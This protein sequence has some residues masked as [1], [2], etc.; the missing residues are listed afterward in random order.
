MAETASQYNINDI[1]EELRPYRNA[2]LNSA[3]GL[4]YTP[5]YLRTQF[6]NAQFPMA[7]PNVT[8]NPP[9]QAQ[10]SLPAPAPQPLFGVDYPVT[11]GRAFDPGR[12]GRGGLSGLAEAADSVDAD[13]QSRERGAPRYGYASGGILSKAADAVDADVTLGPGGT[14]LGGVY[15]V[16]GMPAPNLPVRIGTRT[17]GTIQVPGN[18]PMQP[19]Q[20]PG[21]I[22]GL[23]PPQ[24]TR[25]AMGGPGL[26]GWNTMN[27]SREGV[28]P[29]FVT[30]RPNSF[31]GSSQAAASGYNPAQYADD[32]V[33]GELART[34]GGNLIYT[35]PVG[36]G[37]PPSQATLDFGGNA[38]NNAGLVQQQID[39]ANNAPSQ[40]ERDQRLNALRNEIRS[41][42]GVPGFKK[43]GL[44]RLAEGGFP[45]DGPTNTIGMNTTATA[46][47]AANPFGG[48]TASINP[49]QAYGG[50]RVLGSGSNF[51]QQG[52][53]GVFQVSDPTRDAIQSVQALPTYFDNGEI[54]ANRTEGGAATTPLGIAN[55]IFDASGGLALG[56][57]QNAEYMSGLRPLSS[58]FGNTMNYIRGNPNAFQAGDISVGALTAPQMDAPPAVDVTAGLIDPNNVTQGVGSERMGPVGNIYTDRFVDN[59]NSG[60]YMDPYQ[61]AVTEVRRADALKAFNE[62]KQAR[63][64]QLIR[65]GAF[66]GNRRAVS[67]SLAERDLANQMDRITAEG[68]EGAYLNAQ[69]QYERDRAAKMGVDTTNQR[70]DLEVGGRNLDASLQGASLRTNAGL[71]A[72]LANQRSGLEAALANQNAGIN[73]GSRN[74]DASLT[75]QNLARTSGLAAAQSNQATRLTQ[76]QAL[77]DAAAREDQLKQ[78]ADQGNF[79]NQLNAMGQQTNSALA[80]NTIGQSR[81]DLARLAQSMEIQR[82]REMMGAG[83]GIDSRTQASLDLAYQDFINQRNHPYQQI[84]WLQSL[85]AGTPMGYNQESV[86]FNRTN[87][88]ST[89]GG[90]ATAGIGAL[91]NYYGSK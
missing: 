59:N 15:P 91:S 89:W 5:E 82:I 46:P 45:E 18:I 14:P 25:P 1:P 7:A 84:G 4:V 8:Q 65:A 57:S 66:G 67:E 74:L 60:V 51:G 11:T 37:G 42:G 39:R 68:A 41:L 30:Q 13:L 29:Q 70:K 22:P 31:A 12:V 54:R 47:A 73:V 2:I 50:Q 69:Q 63:N 90:L 32:T 53:N 19:P 77:L 78:Q 26:S 71:Q 86:M 36:A 87:P 28:D 44:T 64:A 49:Y 88:A 75:T 17:D 21:V 61:R 35:N 16:V 38:Q 56:A 79:T 52:Q 58:S 23:Q 34:L 33:A 80:A 3:F 10:Q 55:D 48:S 62:Q 27:P 83:A 81:A 43:G 20:I 9:V 85:L 24:S 6:A 40:G 76:N 72:L